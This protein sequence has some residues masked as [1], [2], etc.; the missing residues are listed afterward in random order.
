MSFFNT[1][2]TLTIYITV[3][4]CRFE[5]FLHIR[6]KFFSLDSFHGLYHFCSSFQSIFLKDYFFSWGFTSG[7]N[8]FFCVMIINI[9]NHICFITSIKKIWL[10]LSFFAIIWNFRFF[11]NIF[12][13]FIFHLFFFRF[14][15]GFFFLSFFFFFTIFLFNTFSLGIFFCYFFRRICFLMNAVCLVQLQL[16][17]LNIIM[18][19]QSKNGQ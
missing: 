18:V 16:K 4:P 1:N 9:F 11:L 19:H 17:S 6:L 7:G 5:M 12:R 3:V 14:F 2:F 10:S 8:S 15:F 13:I